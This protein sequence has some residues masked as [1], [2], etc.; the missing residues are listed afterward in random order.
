MG[1]GSSHVGTPERSVRCAGDRTTLRQRRPTC[2]TVAISGRVASVPP[3]L[4][5]PIPCRRHTP[6]RWPC[7]CE[8]AVVARRPPARPACGRAARPDAWRHLAVFRLGAIE[9]VALRAQSA[10]AM[11]DRVSGQEL[12]QAG[13]LDY[14]QA[15][16]PCPADHHE[17]WL[18]QRGGPVPAGLRRA[19]GPLFVDGSR[20][21]S[22]TT[23]TWTC[24]ASHLRRLADH[25]REGFSSVLYGRTP[26]WRHQRPL[27]RPALPWS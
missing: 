4:P 19:A 10:A 16:S 17:R 5:H 13:R 25:G 12:R 27:A 18:A 1:P 20:C 14:A 21:T 24:T 7:P 22:P 3:V 11:E 6:G 9:V 26:G 8:A 2:N 23:A 15:L